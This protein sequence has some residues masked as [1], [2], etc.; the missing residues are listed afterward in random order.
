MNYLIRTSVNTYSSIKNRSVLF[1]GVYISCRNHSKK[2]TKFSVDSSGL[3][4]IGSN[5]PSAEELR[6]IELS[7]EPLT[8]LVKEL[9][10]A[11]RLRGPMSVHEYMSQSLHHA[12]HGY[13]QHK[14]QKIGKGGDFI[15]SPEI[16]QIFG[17]LIGLWC[18]VVWDEMGSPSKFNLVELGPGTGTLMKDILHIAN[19]FP[20]FRASIDLHMIEL[21]KSMQELQ[22]EKLECISSIH[23]QESKDEKVVKTSHGIPIHWHQYLREV[24]NGPS[25]FLGHEILDAFPVHQ[26]VQSA[27]SKHWREKFVDVDFSLSTPYHFR[28]VQSPSPTSAMTLFMET[29]KISVNDANDNQK[30]SND[31]D[32]LPEDQSQSNTV[33]DNSNTNI[34]DSNERVLSDNSTSTSNSSFSDSTNTS[35]PTTGSGTGMKTKEVSPL[36]LS[37]VEEISKRVMEDKGAA[38]LIDYGS[39]IPDRYVSQVY[40]ISYQYSLFLMYF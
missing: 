21:S 40:H 13:Y 15:T 39:N 16:S 25:I 37:T 36:A 3:L 17:E 35:W 5:W 30:A 14:Q 19:K 23:H 12:Q 33:K 22:Y 6:H 38:L 2:S 4:S 18:I 9:R 7:K 28:F 11:I 27:N 24:P 26:F 20:K 1:N 29:P 8:P 10:S 34:T 32:T 31:S